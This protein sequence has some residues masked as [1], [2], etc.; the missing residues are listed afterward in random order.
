MHEVKL[1][2]GDCLELMKEIPDGSVDMILCDL[3]YGTMKG[4]GLDG[5][6]WTKT[7]WDQRLNTDVL[8]ANYERILRENGMIILFSQEPYTSELR[9][10]N[11]LNI[12]FAYPLVWKKDHFANALISK[13]APVSY[14]EDLSVFY[15]KYDFQNLNPLR[16]YSA[17]LMKWLGASKKQIVD[18]IGQKADHFFRVESTQYKLC[19]QSTYDDL[20]QTLHIDTW[21]G[22]KT[23]ADLAA[24]NSKFQRVFN[25][26]DGQKF[27][28]NVLE[29]RKD[30]Q[31]L[32]PT[33]KPVALLEHLV[34]TYTNPGDLVLDNCMGSG[35]TGVACV[36]TGRRF[37][38]MELDQG[39]FDIAVNRITEAE[40]AVTVCG[41]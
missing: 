39:Y 14:F 13:K 32:H 40:K 15:K 11:H 31:G 23:Y 25:L 1:L 5:W 28:G 21:E 3:P 9:K 18:A 33:Q 8:F 12:D 27:I 20:I 17:D 38:G 2:H 37:I 24:V 34:K 26:P 30:Y 29:Y 7:A 6:D 16:K 41:K 19:T 22:F 10:L 36:N 4:A 35:S